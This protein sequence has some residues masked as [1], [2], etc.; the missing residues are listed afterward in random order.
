MRLI[1]LGAPGAGKGTIAEI[2]RARLNIPTISTGNILR[3]A[4]LNRTKLGRVA[5]PYIDAGKLVPDNVIIE[6]IK[7]RL[8]EADCKNGFILD[9]VP[10]TAAQAAAL[11]EIGLNIDAVLMV[12]ASDEVIERRLSDAAYVSARATY[13][14]KKSRPGR[15]PMRFGGRCTEPTTHP[16]L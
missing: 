1:L 8:S 4:I 5:K 9:G 15:K 12:E 16:K 6:L 13:H 3:E 10:R 7:N 11:D 2:I 14:L